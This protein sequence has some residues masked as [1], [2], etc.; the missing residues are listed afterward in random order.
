MDPDRSALRQ[1]LGRPV[2]PPYAVWFVFASVLL[3]DGFSVL[4]LLAYGVTMALLVLVLQGTA[5]ASPEARR[6]GLIALGATGVAIGGEI[7][8][9]SGASRGLV[10]WSLVL[11]VVVRAM[12]DL[13][14]S[15]LA[16]AAR[17]RGAVYAWRRA[18]VFGLVV[19]VVGVLTLL[20]THTL[21]ATER[22]STR[23]IHGVTLVGGG[24]ILGLLALLLVLADVVVVVLAMRAT[25]RTSAEAALLADVG[26]AA[27]LADDL[28]DDVLADGGPL[29]GPAR[30]DDDPSDRA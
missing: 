12:A 14:M 26:T 23:R 3:K 2:V 9:L 13:M 6:Y 8:F 4:M 25:D 24:G 10:I 1:A 22:A 30:L 29:V 18:H 17:V 15:H 16:G 11:F 21:G 19:G 5:G 7:G 27:R 20:T 28:D